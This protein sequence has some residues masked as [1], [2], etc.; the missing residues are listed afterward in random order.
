MKFKM[1]LIVL[2]CILGFAQAHEISFSRIKLEVRQ[3][4]QIQL[5]MPVKDLA[6]QLGN[7]APER[8]LQ[9]QNLAKLEPE[10]LVLVKKRL[11]LEVAGQPLRFTDFKLQALPNRKEI[12]VIWQFASIQQTFLVQSNLFPDNPLHKTFLDV[13][14]DNQLEQQLIFD[15]N[16]T[17]ATIQASQQSVWQVVWNFVLEGIHH[18]FIGFDHILFIVG[19]LL[20]GGNLW[21]LL[22]IVSAFTLAHSITLVLATLQILSPPA[23]LV[24]VIIAASIVF[25]GVH[26]FFKHKHDLRIIFAF[27]F[28]LIHG[29]GFASVLSE[30]ELPQEA[31]AWALLAFNG[32][33]EIGQMCI[34]LLVAPLLAWL[35][36]HHPNNAALTIRV[37]SLAV[38]AAGAYWFVERVVGA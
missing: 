25:V 6:R 23:R 1:S 5:E 3:P 8:L 11:I 35:R 38:I 13:Y 2:W 10:I 12:Q 37:A 9:A 26:G 27:G 18:I 34:V 15:A 16:K 36:R 31:L 32:G 29:F 14:K 4:S 7:I 33:V 19:L 22:K 30:L 17:R 28:G 24:E 21:Q 20:L